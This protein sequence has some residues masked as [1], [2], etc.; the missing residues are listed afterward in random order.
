MSIIDEIVI[1]LIILALGTVFRYLKRSFVNDSLIFVG[2]VL[3]LS[4]SFNALLNVSNIQLT[5]AEALLALIFGSAIL[6]LSIF[7]IAH[8]YVERLRR[9]YGVPSKQR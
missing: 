6:V 8:D 9:K 7:L 4:F 2:S 3:F 1:S 5:Y